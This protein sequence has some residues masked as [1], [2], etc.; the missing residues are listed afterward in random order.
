MIMSSYLMDSNYIDPKFPPCEEYSQN[1]YIPDHSPEYYSRTRGDPGY[2]HHHQELFPPRPSY[3]DRQY[4]CGSIPDPENPTA[5]Q[6]GHG[7]PPAGH[8]L[9][10]KPQA[11]P[12]ESAAPLP[13]TPATPSPAPPPP[14]CSQANPD[15]PSTTASTKQP[16]VY[17]WMKKIH[18]STVSDIL[19]PLEESYK[20]VSMEGNNLGAPLAVYRQS[21]V[22]QASMQQQ[23]H[24]GHNGTVPATYH[25]AAA[26]VPQLS[27]ASMG[28]YCNGNLG[29]L[30]NM[31]E[32]PPYQE[33]MRNSASATGCAETSPPSPASKRARTAYTNSQLVELEK[34]FHFNRYLCRPRRVEMAKLLTLTE[35]QIKIW[36]Q[37]R[38]MKYKKDH[39]LKGGVSSSPGGSPSQSPLIGSYFQPSDVGYEASLPNTYPKPHGNVYGLAAYSTPLYDCPPPQKRCR[40]AAV[41]SDYDP[42]SLQEDGYGSHILQGSPGYAEPSY[43]ESVPGNSGPIFNLPHASSS[44]DYSCTAQIPGKHPLG[45]CEPHPSYAPPRTLRAPPVLH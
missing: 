18:V 40:V 7:R 29:N 1:S 28:G 22:S 12:C 13:N 20:K 10:A 9:A 45:P 36:F 19:S 33:T 24:M 26:G 17:P 15:H 8:L 35:R 14:S 30:G 32:L 3:Q 37:N 34:E 43:R 16:V 25:M 31:S 5:H 41:A 6:R 27:H 21:H 44:L 4:S 11:A 23:H 2:Q 39:K 42:L 38:R